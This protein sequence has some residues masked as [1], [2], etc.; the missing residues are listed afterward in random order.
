MSPPPLGFRGK[1]WG[2][3]SRGLSWAVPLEASAHA[4]AGGLCASGSAWCLSPG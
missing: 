1:N 3:Q 2:P 4:E